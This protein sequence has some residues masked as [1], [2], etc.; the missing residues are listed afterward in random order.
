M[1][2]NKCGGVV[3]EDIH[4]EG[5]VIIHHKKNEYEKRDKRMMRMKG[6][7]W[8]KEEEKGMMRC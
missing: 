8:G 6:K 3:I 5:N 7:E 1:Q 4:E 2:E